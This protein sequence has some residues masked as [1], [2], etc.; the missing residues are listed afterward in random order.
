MLQSLGTTASDFQKGQSTNSTDSSF[1]SIVPTTTEPEAAAT[2]AVIEMRGSN[3]QQSNSNLC[4]VF[5]GT[6]NDDTTIAIRIVG[7]RKVGTLWV[8]T[9]LLELTATLSAAV[10]V[11]GATVIDTERFADTLAPAAAWEDLEGSAFTITSPTNNLI[12]QVLIDARG[13]EKIEI[14]YDLTGATAANCLYAGL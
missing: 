14:S 7:W 6:G 13:Y 8:P 3:T 5:Y 4:L 12:A 9:V 1:D 10:G 2:R 11:S